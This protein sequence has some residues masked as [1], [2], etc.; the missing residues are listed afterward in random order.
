MATSSV[1][2]TETTRINLANSVTVNGITYPAGKNVEVP[3][4]Q[5]D[6]IARID[7]DHQQ[8]LS[9]LH[10]KSVYE[11]NSGTMAVGGGE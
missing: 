4:K 9:T 5:A 3:K 8:Y 11:V 6:D 7:Y 1:G 10:K 2:S